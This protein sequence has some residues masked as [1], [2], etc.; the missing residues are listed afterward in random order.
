MVCLRSHGESV[1]ELGTEAG[2]E[3]HAVKPALKD[4]QG[5]LSASSL[6][7]A[8]CLEGALKWLLKGCVLERY[9]MSILPAASLPAST[10]ASRTRLAGAE[11][12]ALWWGFDVTS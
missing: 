3:S 8:R 6:K 11:V 10:S 1:A 12:L 5:L 7:T 2:C 9:L 4:L